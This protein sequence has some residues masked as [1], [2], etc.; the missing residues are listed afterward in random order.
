MSSVVSHRSPGPWR[1]CYT[2]CYTGEQTC[3]QPQ[4][5]MS[6]PTTAGKSPMP[7]W[8]WVRRVPDRRFVTDGDTSAVVRHAR[9]AFVRYVDS[10]S[11]PVSDE[12]TDQAFLFSSAYAT[13]A[14]SPG[15][16]SGRGRPRSSANTR[17]PAARA[18]PC[19]ILG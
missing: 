15:P 16:S 14:S 13:A 11:L 3:H 4:A 8:R 1:L 9:S 10:G 19:P 7:S 5:S 17:H 6:R 2:R 18:G 12:R